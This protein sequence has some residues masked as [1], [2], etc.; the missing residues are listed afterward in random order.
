MQKL[1]E[2][3]ES[4]KI[5]SEGLGISERMLYRYVNSLYEKAGAENRAGLVKRYYEDKKS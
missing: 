3:D 1:L 2:S 5:V 4:M